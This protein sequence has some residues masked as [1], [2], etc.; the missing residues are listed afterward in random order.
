MGFVIV[1]SAVMVPVHVLKV[2]RMLTS[3]EEC[4]N[5]I[6]IFFQD[7]EELCVI[8]QLIQII[9]AEVCVTRR[10]IVFLQ[11]AYMVLVCA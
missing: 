9:S 4:V 2:C 11:T 3:C 6:E 8:N 1:V 7:T 10:L 5:M